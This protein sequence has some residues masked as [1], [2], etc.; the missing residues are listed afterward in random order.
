MPEQGE[1]RPDETQSRS[2]LVKA[3]R[4]EFKNK[5]INFQAKTTKGPNIK[6]RTGLEEYF[7]YSFDEGLQQDLSQCYSIQDRG[8][9]VCLLKRPPMKKKKHF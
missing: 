7:G 9:K 4:N 2:D 6:Y 3:R 8:D 5:L 1:H